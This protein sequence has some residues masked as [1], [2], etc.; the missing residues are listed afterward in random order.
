MDMTFCTVCAQCQILC[1]ETVC[2]QLGDYEGRKLD[3]ESYATVAKEW[4]P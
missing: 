3:F 4:V 2:Q 1:H